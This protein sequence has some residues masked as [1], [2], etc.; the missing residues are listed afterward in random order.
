MT[1]KTPAPT[2]KPQRLSAAQLKNLAHR[3]I[4]TALAAVKRSTVVAADATPQEVKYA[5]TLGRELS[6]IARALGLLEI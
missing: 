5:E 2:P 6:K 1:D 3:E 4:L